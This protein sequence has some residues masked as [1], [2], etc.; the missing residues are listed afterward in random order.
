MSYLANVRARLDA[1]RDTSL[2][3]TVRASANDPARD[4]SSN[5]YLGMSRHP[6]VVAALRAA[7]VAG[8]G[9]ARLLAGAHAEHVALEVALAAWVGREAA[10]VF[11]SGYLA[12][13]GAI[14]A[15][16]PHVAVAYSDE[17]NH[18]CAIDALRLTKL[19]R[20]IYPHR[21]LP[22]IAKRTSRAL[23]VTETL[24]GME[25]SRIDVAPLAASLGASDV[26][27]V[28]EAHALGLEGKHG[29]GLA[30]HV[31][32]ERIVVIGTLSKA[33]GTL[34]GF[35]AGPRDVISLLQNDARAFVFDTALP[36]A[37]AEAA[38]F[39]LA[40]VAGAEGDTRR[41]RVRTHAARV[42]THLGAL[43]LAAS[44][45]GG[46]IVPIVLG[47]PEA[48]LAFSRALA[49][50]GIVAPAIRPPTVPRGESMIRLTLRA[51]HTDADVTDLLAALTHARA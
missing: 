14:G 21:M 28:D 42:R 3:R 44:G 38:C 46:A 33:L 29:G 4:F 6:H 30:R 43:G 18:A 24:F 39:A 40:L 51:D 12:A 13:L 9:G 37:I 25:G 47:T 7:S 22:Q 8:S 31:A 5:D 17:R 23:V 15:L 26:L 48:A 10:L 49:T 35:V 45:E 32:D 11:S 50:F 16:A 1:L 34:G 36:P 20:T 2:L 27:V 41:A 19:P